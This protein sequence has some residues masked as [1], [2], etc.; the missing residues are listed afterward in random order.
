MNKRCTTCETVKPLE[1][2]NKGRAYC[3]PCH[4]AASLAWARANKEKRR[5]IANA[6]TARRRA[7]LGPPKKGGRL[8]VLSPEEAA[9]R[10]AEAKRRWERANP[11]LVLAKTRAYQAQKIK[12]LPKWADKRAIEAIYQRARAAGLHVDHIVPLQSEIVCGLHC[13]ANLQLL[14]PKENWSKNNRRWPDMP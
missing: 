5:A 14:A 8:A 9:R 7:A 13:E 4:A 1:Q 3:K 6:Y 12:A 10:D 11:A 2:F